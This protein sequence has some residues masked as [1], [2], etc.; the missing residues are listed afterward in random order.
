MSI[1]TGNAKLIKI[2]GEENWK[3][4]EFVES[5]LPEEQEAGR[6]LVHPENDYNL[7]GSLRAIYLKA[8][9]SEDKILEETMNSIL[10]SSYSTEE[11]QKR[12]HVQEEHEDQ[13][14][15]QD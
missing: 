5:M 13:E 11:K 8:H 12:R 10:E 15:Y 2:L 6:E 9:A 7:S 4:E 1:P 14:K 3:D